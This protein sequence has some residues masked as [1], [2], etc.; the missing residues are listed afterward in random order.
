MA[1]PSA[2]R[3]R[4]LDLRSQ[5]RRCGY[6]DGKLAEAYRF[7]G[8][9]VPLAGFSGQ[10]HDS[11]SACIA[12]IE[13][14]FNVEQEVVRVRDTGAP[15]V[16]ACVGTQLQWWKQTSSS[17]VRIES[18]PQPN[19]ANF[20]AQHRAQLKPTT[21]Y[22]AK[23]RGRLPGHH[24]LDFVDVGLMPL[25]EGV[26]GKKLSD[27]LTRA[28]KRMEEV[29]GK[30]LHLRTA[31]V[32][33]LYK[34]AFWLVAAKMLRD[35]EV[36]NFKTL[37]LKDINDVF[38]RVGNHYGDMDGLPP[39]GSSWRPAIES[40]AELI[41]KFSHLGNVSTEALAHVYENTLV[42]KEVRKS[43][44]IHSTPSALVDYIV[45]QL[46][47]WIAEIP[48]DHRH[49]FE[50]ACGHAG[51]LVA[52]LRQLSQW[53]SISDGKERHKY[54][55]QHLHGLEYDPF[56]IEI[57]KLSL[58][59]ADIPH[60]NSWDLRQ[61]NMFE[62]SVLARE[63]RRAMILLANPPYEKLTASE[64]SKYGAKAG[65]KATEVMRRTLEHLPVGACFGVVLPAG[66]LHGLEAK[67]LR[68]DLLSKFE[69]AEIAVFEDKL[70]EHGEHEVAVLIGRRRAIKATARTLSFRRVRNV[71]MQ[72]F[73]EAFE[74]SSTEQADLAA[75][76]TTPHYDMR[77]PELA[78]LWAYLRGHPRLDD[79]A[80]VGQ[81]LSFKG[82]Q[83]LP[84][85]SWT[86]RRLQK[87]DPQGFVELEPALNIYGTPSVAGMNLSSNVILRPRHGRATGHPQ[88]LFNYAR[89]SRGP[90]RLKAILD[91]VGRAFTSNFVTVRPKDFSGIPLLC[92]WAILNSPLANAYAYVTFFGKRSHV[93]GPMRRLPIPHRLRE[94]CDTIVASAVHYL[95]LA[96]PR[97][98]SPISPK[99]LVHAL[100]AVDAAVLKAYGLPPKLERQLLNLFEGEERAGVGVAFT[101][102]FLSDMKAYVPLQE[103]LSPEY[104]R[105]TAGALKAKHQPTSDERILAALKTADESFGEE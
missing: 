47:P 70:F 29:L 41:S 11:R 92:L 105:S 21:V 24:Q 81:G 48:E 52:M 88:V 61:G 22:D 34:S 44:G 31:A 45:W 54:L 5:L 78:A 53:S 90:W 40:A 59:L 2:P 37:D 19:V 36:Q 87:G 56:A 14:E 83:A 97:F 104:Q 101:G 57:A 16:F 38:R 79:V 67:Q 77:V 50:P 82:K 66:F 12:V 64:R 30:S 15:V 35:K 8:D 58:T 20:F 9:S 27:L 17:P 28:I 62:D 13:A 91:D 10:P 32:N 23:T 1:S 60:G 73:R 68:A 89:V 63:A 49:V 25:V 3:I 99:G 4:P 74:F 46:W 51:F 55:R 76:A 71:D 80:V 75:Y 102:Y 85:G 6:D 43:L 95:E 103:F 33:D 39:G 84:P 18:V 26:A 94:H 96:S 7:N 69:V 72:R 100:M 65:T 98:G 86:V 93:V 42:P